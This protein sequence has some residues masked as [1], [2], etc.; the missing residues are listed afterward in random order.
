MLF[1]QQRHDMAQALRPSTVRKTLRAVKQSIRTRFTRFP[2]SQNHDTTPMDASNNVGSSSTEV[3]VPGLTPQTTPPSAPLRSSASV[4]ASQGS[5]QCNGVSIGIQA[6]SAPPSP[7]PAPS[8]PSSGLDSP[9]E[10]NTPSDASRLQHLQTPQAVAPARRAPHVAHLT[11]GFP[12]TPRDID[13]LRVLD[14]TASKWSEYAQKAAQCADRMHTLLLDIEG[15]GAPAAPPAPSASGV[16]EVVVDPQPMV[17]EAVNPNPE[18]QA[19]EQE[20]PQAEN[21]NPVENTAALPVFTNPKSGHQ[22]TVHGVVGEGSFGRV[23]KVTDKND[24]CFAVKTIH[25]RLAYQAGGARE[26]LC[27]EFGA[28]RLVQSN[29]P[30]NGRLVRLLE[31]WEDPDNVYFVMVRLVFFVCAAQAH[32]RSFRFSL[33][34]RTRSGN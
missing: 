18:R 14:A 15:T 7:I 8:S 11:H 12:S 4:H 32:W 34:T 27:K 3:G 1:R 22:Y 6:P 10:Y 19:M 28:M 13:Q 5:P 17:D 33:C 25:K 21:G 20:P 24:Q 9:F 2:S 31:S 29:K 26:Q 30:H 16:Q 23:L